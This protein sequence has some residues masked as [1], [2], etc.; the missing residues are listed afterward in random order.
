MFALFLA[1]I[2][3]CRLFLFL[4][5]ENF[6]VAFMFAMFYENKLSPTAY[7]CLLIWMPLFLQKEKRR[8]IDKNR[9][10]N[11]S[12]NKRL[13]PMDLLFLSLEC[14]CRCRWV[15]RRQPKPHTRTTVLRTSK[16][17]LC[18]ILF[19]THLCKKIIWIMETV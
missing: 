14:G 19:F 3:G 18:A 8:I 12:M 2:F 15:R 11:I 17:F 6:S 4:L 7:S 9:F 5:K 13:P 1:D 10:M 16:R